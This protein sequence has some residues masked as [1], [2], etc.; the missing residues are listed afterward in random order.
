MDFITLCANVCQFQ[1]YDEPVLGDF[2]TTTDAQLKRVKV[3]VNQ[4]YRMLW[5]EFNRRNEYSEGE[6]TITT[7]V[8]QEAYDIPA[9]LESVDWMAYGNNPPMRILPFREFEANYRRTDYLITANVLG[10]PDVA[11][12]WDRKIYINPIP[13]QEYILNVRGRLKFAELV[14]PTDE[15]LFP[16]VLCDPIQEIAITRL[17]FYEGNPGA[18]GQAQ[19]ANE[20]KRLAK[21]AFRAHTGFAPRMM[22]EQEFMNRSRDI[23]RP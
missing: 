16:N 6:A 20:C 21:A 23:R 17:Q 8:N 18:D 12:I 10:W 4:A 15:P 14:N 19:F 11:A 5:N 3:A 22:H 2:L 7:A 13:D 1:D 9:T